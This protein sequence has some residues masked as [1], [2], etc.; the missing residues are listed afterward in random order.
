[1]ESVVSWNPREVSIWL[2]KK[3]HSKYSRILT[4]D[5]CIDGRALL[6]INEADLKSP[7]ISINVLGDIKRLMLDIR[8][9]KVE[10]RQTLLQLGFDPIS[11]LTKPVCSCTCLWNSIPTR[12]I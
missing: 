9:L 10:N 12:S 1:M 6:L 2:E 8:Q 5:H 7:P 11:L 4:E 3:G